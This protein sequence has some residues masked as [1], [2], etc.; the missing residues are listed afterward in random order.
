M[1]GVMIDQ[2]KTT[3]VVIMGV[4]QRQLLVAMRDIAG[5]VDIQNDR[6]RLAF[7]RRHPLIDERVGQADHVL[8]RGRVLQPRQRRL[9]TRVRAAVRQS[10]AAI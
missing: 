3:A 7:V 1:F 2:Q 5:V 8:Q 9:R 4:E 6:D 10:P